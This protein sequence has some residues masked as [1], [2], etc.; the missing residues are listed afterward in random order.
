MS[1]D[2]LSPVSNDSLKAVVETVLNDLGLAFSHT[3]EIIVPDELQKSVRLDS[4]KGRFVRI[5]DDG[6]ASDIDLKEFLAGAAKDQ[7][8]LFQ[9]RATSKPSTST[10]KTPDTGN[11]TERM[12]QIR[13]TRET[14]VSKAMKAKAEAIGSNPWKS[15]NLTEQ[16]FI[17]KWNPE[18][19]ERLK[20]EAGR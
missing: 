14:P 19:A 7:P 12:R 15:G 10:A 18:Q 8:D 11:L 17:R 4:F 1:T 3:G 2:H 16:M 6:Q 13:A 20:Q 5:S 9:P